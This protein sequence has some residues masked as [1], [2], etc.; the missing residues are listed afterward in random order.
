MN[1]DPIYNYFDYEGNYR[2]NYNTDIED[3]RT[4]VDFLRDSGYTYI[5]KSDKAIFKKGNRTFVGV[6]D[7]EAEAITRGFL[8]FLRS[9]D[10]TGRQ[11]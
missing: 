5:Q 8:A 4:L 11:S 6:G 2:P 10:E 1:L 9:Y 3:A 7:S